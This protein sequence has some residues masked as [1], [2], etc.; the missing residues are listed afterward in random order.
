MN[1]YGIII[2]ILLWVTGIIIMVQFAYSSQF[3]A[4]N[5]FGTAIF[6]AGSTTT[7]AYAPGY[8]RTIIIG[9]GLVKLMPAEIDNKYDVIM[10]DKLMLQEEEE[11]ERLLD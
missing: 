4:G 10:F 6:G 5:I 11:W 1:R 8:H 9:G 2:G 7:S 3:G